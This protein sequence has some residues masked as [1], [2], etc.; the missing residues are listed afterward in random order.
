MSSNAFAPLAPLEPLMEACVHC[1]FCLPTCP[2]YV[3]LGRETD[4]P[5]GR[6]YLMR[7]G[8]DERVTMS[9]T[10]VH[11]FDTCLGCVACETACPSGVKYGPLIERTRA[12]IEQHAQR[13]A[14]ERLFRRLLFSI[15]PYPAR[16]RALAVPLRYQRWWRRPGL[17][18]RLPAMMRQALSL[19]PDLPSGAD[20]NVPALTPAAGERR[21]KVGLLTGCVQRVFFGS[22][23]AA[24]ARVLAAKGCE[25]HAPPEQG[26]CGALSLHSGE[27]AQAKTLAR[28][29]IET[30]E[31]ADV[32]VVAVNAAGCG[33]A[34][35]GYAQLFADEPAWAERGRRF[36]AKV[37]DVSE[38][39][40]A[41]AAGDPPPAAAAAPAGTITVAY[42]DACHLAHAQGIRREPR[43]LLQAIPGVRL[44]PFGE[45]EI[46]CGS[47]GIFNL[48]QPEIATV[49]GDRKA[50]NIHAVHPDLV[51]TTNPGCILQIRAAAKR[52]GHTYEVMHLME[53]IDGHQPE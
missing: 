28:R 16:L 53:F 25:V 8:L 12:T 11:H 7:A 40:D 37:R 49:L 20:A 30:F 48:V 22:V 47:A 26:C 3:V 4:S 33:S 13:P 39:L 31:A 23:N 52:A 29:L 19:A 21:I 38:V 50:A 27:E 18:N 44:V 35:K 51:V 5:R 9:D 43:A 34:M 24:T 41:L 10:V 6:I 14:S 42:H 32:D 36:A 2:S 1:G 45:P 15:L 46:C 17:L